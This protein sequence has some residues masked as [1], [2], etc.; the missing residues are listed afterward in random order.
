[1][2]GNLARTEE[3]LGFD[4]VRRTITERCCTDY[5][6]ARV[7]N[8]SFCTN[9]AQIRLRLQLTDEMRLICMFEDSF[10]ASGFVDAL[11]F[12]ELLEDEGSRIDVLSLGKLKTHLDTIRKITAFFASVKDGVYRKHP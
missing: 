8:E 7:E 4:R 10:P 12:L 6:A 9:P 11:P 5:A 1:M 3:K 2:D